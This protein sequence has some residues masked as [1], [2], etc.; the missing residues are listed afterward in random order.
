MQKII[1]LPILLILFISTASACWDV[2]GWDTI[3][4]DTCPVPISQAQP[5]GSGGGSGDSFY[6]PPAPKEKQI[7]GETVELRLKQG[8]SYK[9]IFKTEDEHNLTVVKLYSD[10]VNIT[11]FS[12]VK[13]AVLYVGESIIFEFEPFLKL[14]VTLKKIDGGFA[15]FTVKDMTNYPLSGGMG[16]GMG[17]VTTEVQIYGEPVELEIIQ[18]PQV[19]SEEPSS[20]VPPQP[21]DKSGRSWVWVALFV[22]ICILFWVYYVYVYKK[23]KENGKQKA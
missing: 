4:W 6:T 7:D 20:L 10:K 14:S 13:N 15:V 1:L 8:N 11:A 23:G 22:V 18:E 9:I 21:D 19:L 12:T 16:G 17:D 5:S 2:V 3:G